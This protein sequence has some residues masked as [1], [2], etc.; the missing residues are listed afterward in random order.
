[1]PDRRQHRGAHPLDRE[2]FDASALPVLRQAV[3]DYC[4]L[5]TRGYAPL[6]ALKLVGD[7]H[8]LRERQRVAVSRVS[9]SEAA[10]A[11]RQARRVS[12]S[13]LSLRELAV[14]GFNAIISVEVALGGGVGLI[15]RDGARR[16]L[17]SV[18][19]T[20]RRVIETPRA[21]ELLVTAVMSCSP[22]AVVWYLDRPV[23]NSGKLASML[24]Q[25]CTLA[26]HATAVELVDDVD[27]RVSQPGVIA[28]SADSA[29]MEAAEH[30]FDLAGWVVQQH[31]PG[32]WTLDFDA[33]TCVHTLSS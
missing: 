14:D 27:R 25:H 32:A 23:S 10:L 3:L 5:M 30:W 11:R 19:G 26:G 4:W 29:V 21:L 12:P 13:E 20:Y 24:R 33:V 18:H 8:R 17:A 7:H 28:L 2:L 15:A 9:C 22:A 6:A 1:M 16:D 31:V